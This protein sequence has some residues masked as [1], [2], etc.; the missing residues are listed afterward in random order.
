DLDLQIEVLQGNGGTEPF[1]QALGANGT[2]HGQLQNAVSLHRT[3]E[4]LFAQVFQHRLPASGNYPDAG[5]TPIA[6]VEFGA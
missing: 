5:R 6:S 2:S 3:A 4:T 1:G